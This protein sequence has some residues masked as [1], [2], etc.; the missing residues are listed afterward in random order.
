M[1]FPGAVHPERRRLRA[2][3]LRMGSPDNHRCKVVRGFRAQ[4]RGISACCMLQ[5]A[6]N[7]QCLTLNFSL[8]VRRTSLSILEPG[9]MLDHYHNS[10]STHFCGVLRIEKKTKLMRAACLSYVCM[11]AS[12]RYGTFGFKCPLQIGCQNVTLMSVTKKSNSKKRL[13]SDIR[14][15]MPDVTGFFLTDIHCRH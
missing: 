7:N 11:F 12:Y 14:T 8:P 3:S 10:Q 9:R 4:A 1:S 6:S 13:R 15:V 2:A 5:Q